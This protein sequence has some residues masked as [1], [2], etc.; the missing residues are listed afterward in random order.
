MEKKYNFNTAISLVVGIVIGSGIFFKADDVLAAVNGNVLLG[1]LGFLIVGIGVLFGA[2]TVSYYTNVDTENIGLIGYARLALGKK[3]AFIVG[4]F[5]IACYFPAIV[6]ILAMVASIYLGVL[7]NI[8]N[9]L[10]QT[11]AT[12]IFIIGAFTINI[13]SPE[14]GGK[15]QVIFTIAKLIPLILIGIIGTFFFSSSESLAAVADAGISGGTPL[16]ALI[17]IAF[18]FDGWIVATSIARDLENSKKNLPKALAFGTVIIILVYTLYFFGMTQILD[19]A[20]IIAQGDAHTQLAAQQILGPL[21]GKIIT[22]FV[23]ISVC[24]GLNGMTLAYIR[25]PQV[26]VDAG[27][28]R[29]FFGKDE[30][31]TKRGMLLFC[32]GVVS[33]IFFFN[34]LVDLG[35]IFS[36]LASPFDVSTLPILI[37]QIVYV[38]IFLMVNKYTKN[39]KPG[40]RAFYLISSLIATITSSVVIYGTLGVNGLLYIV[41]SIIICLIGIPF[42]NKEA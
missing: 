12:A 8:D 1:V 39:E 5:S 17:I 31:S 3:F 30:A 34:M 11:I 19:P 14:T 13:K 27:I 4:W 37:N 15:L 6:F 23:V 7:L 41:V 25:L 24:G 36:N 38:C 10:F 22:A 18:A 20:T 32:F 42:Y 16:T 9:Y 2:L 28:I 26:C 40:K 33:A 21:G 35:I 29:N